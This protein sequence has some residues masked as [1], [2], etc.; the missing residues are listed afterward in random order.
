MKEYRMV[1]LPANFQFSKNHETAIQR[2]EDVVN[3]Y[4]A[5]GWTLQQIISHDTPGSI[6]IG[7][8]WRER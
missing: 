5:D 1:D 2:I 6:L 3:E 4:A 8:F 7:V